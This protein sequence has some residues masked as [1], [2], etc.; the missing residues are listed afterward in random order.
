[1]MKFSKSP[2]PDPLKRPRRGGGTR[3]RGPTRGAPSLPRLPPPPAVSRSPERSATAPPAATRSDHP[4][5]TR[6]AAR[7]YFSP[8]FP[9]FHPPAPPARFC[10]MEPDSRGG[11]G[12]RSHFLVHI[13][14]RLPPR[15]APAAARPGPAA[16]SR[17][18]PEPRRGAPGPL[19]ARPPP[20][21]HLGDHPLHFTRYSTLPCGAREAKTRRSAGPTARPPA[22]PLSA[23]PP[24]S[25]R[26]FRIRFFSMLSTAKTCSPTAGSS[27]L[28]SGRA[29]PGVRA[30][31]CG[32]A[33]LGLRQLPPPNR[34]TLRGGR[35]TATHAN[36]GA[37]RQGGGASRARLPVNGGAGGLA[38]RCRG[39][40]RGGGAGAGRRGGT[41]ERPG[42][43]PTRDSARPRGEGRCAAGG[44]A[45]P[46][47]RVRNP[48]RGCV[49]IEPPPEGSA[50]PWAAPQRPGPPRLPPL[51]PAHGG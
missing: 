26:T 4:D 19:S 9:P 34:Q 40:R 29:E 10:N 21:T 33:G 22:A 47:V 13:S 36:P 2:F 24:L 16:A 45:G 46:E 32:R 5:P 6:G 23:S 14:R 31:R 35:G 42:P 3:P 51:V 15:S 39:A 11:K 50:L 20:G 44:A 7:F 37:R 48:P 38:Q 1:M 25:L 18:P 28:R 17:R 30:A 12:G 41:R 49:G 27:M 43:R 8:Y